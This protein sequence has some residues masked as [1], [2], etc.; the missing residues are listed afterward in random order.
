MNLNQVTVPT[1]NMEDSLNFY[2]ILGFQLLVKS[3][4]YLRFK[5][6]EGESTFSVILS[7]SKTKE[8]P[9]HVY[10]E[11]TELDKT[12]KK[13]KAKGVSFTQDPIDQPWL[14]REAHLKDPAGNE[15]ILYYAG[16]NRL[17]PPWKV[18]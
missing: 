6:P 14:W 10:F 3:P 18:L 11:C 7:E 8:N 2:Q 4:H 17:I 13:L 9:I 5:V 16:E 1:T 15:L 12:V